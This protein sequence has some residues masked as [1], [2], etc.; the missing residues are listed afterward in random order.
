MSANVEAEVVNLVDVIMADDSVT[1]ESYIA[2][3]HEYAVSEHRGRLAEL[4]VD[5]GNGH[6]LMTVGRVLASMILLHPYR[7]AKIPPS[8]DRFMRSYLTSS[9]IEDH[10]SKTIEELYSHMDVAELS[11]TVSTT[12]CYLADLACDV[13]GR[14]GT[15]VSIKGI[16]EAAELDPE[17]KKLLNWTSPGGE[18]GDMERAADEASDELVHRMKALPG[19]I[20]RLLRCGAAVNKGQLRQAIVNIGVKP[21]LM[22]GELMSEPV[23]TSFLRG[24]RNV[25]DYYI[26]AIGARKALTTNYKQVKNSGYLSRKLVL[27][28]VNHFINMEETDCGTEHGVR[29]TIQSE[30]HA[31]RLSGRYMRT[32]EHNDWKIYYPRALK[33]MI[34]QEVVMR[35]PMTCAGSDGIC[36]KCY[37]E[38][39]RS[40]KHIHAGIYGVLI[41]SAQLIQRLLSSKHLLKARPVKITWPDNFH[42]FFSVERTTI[43]AESSV[44]RIYV[45]VDDIEDDEEEGRRAT[46]VFYYRAGGK[47]GRTKVTTP[48]PLILDEDTW[49]TDIDDGELVISPTQDS[50]VFHVP[51]TNTDL[52][53]ALHRIFG[54][55]ERE[56]LTNL[57]T[58]Y[59]QFSELLTRSELQTPSVHIEI[60]LRA[61][62]RSAAD[63]MARPDFS[64]SPD[65]PA[66]T[67][68]KL[69][70][71]IIMSPSVTNS[72][73]FE[74]VKAQLTST[75]ILRKTQSSAIDALFGG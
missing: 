29:F 48:V 4:D 20:G 54:L 59:E 5:C 57:H 74:R 50:T 10:L 49:I 3:L 19:E 69:K 16:Y 15:S 31:S 34:G 36:H 6:E 63:T 30:D 13:T 27:L 14:V 43:L 45:R 58:A 51:V 65:E 37:G 56:D 41:I 40:N 62:I 7:E 2:S 21:G 38:H 53:E 75:D 70:P 44:D 60:I 12:L 24:L 71:A 28:V 68:L 17:I 55:I 23:E 35:S 39:A 42:E 46:S 72:L 25:E 73:A 64:V 47:H 1:Y 11:L 32:A 66:Y 18:L 26:C 67:I 52:S 22:D 33:E 9:L 8:T 61:M